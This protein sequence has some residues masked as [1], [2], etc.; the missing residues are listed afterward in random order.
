MYIT[1]IIQCFHLF[2]LQ[3][4]PF[5]Q[6]TG[7]FSELNKVSASTDVTFKLQGGWKMQN[8]NIMHS[9][10]SLATNTSTPD[11]PSTRFQHTPKV[12]TV[13]HGYLI[14]FS[15]NYH[16]NVY[17]YYQMVIATFT[18]DDF[19]VGITLLICIPWEQQFMWSN[20][21]TQWWG[22]TQWHT[23]NEKLHSKPTWHT[24][25]VRVIS[26][27]SLP[28]LLKRLNLLLLF[29]CF[30][31]FGFRKNIWKLKL[32][33]LWLKKKEEAFSVTGKKVR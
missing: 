8:G 10:I 14:T 24:R 20:T 25:P 23:H 18:Q 31:F 9:L 32:L 27:I 5:I 26:S 11:H 19:H 7:W 6:W 3:W 33:I 12:I 28:L 29:L 13:N 1:N 30:L 2:T 21:D 22:P 15:S 16:Q 4:P 17:M